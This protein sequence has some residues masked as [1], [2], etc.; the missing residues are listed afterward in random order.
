MVKLIGGGTVASFHL[1]M[2]S[3][4]ESVAVHVQLMCG[5]GM[6]LTGPGGITSNVLIWSQALW[7]GGNFFVLS[8]FHTVPYIRRPLCKIN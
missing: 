4:S 2:S 1:G 8:E 7:Y 6:A 5:S 3:L